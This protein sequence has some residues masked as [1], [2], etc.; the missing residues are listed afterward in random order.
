MAR[1]GDDWIG[2]QA[3]AN[4]R[5]EGINCDYITRD[6]HTPSGVALIMVDRAAENLIGAA[7]SANSTLTP[8]HVAQAEN[9]I[10]ESDVLIVQ[11]EIPLETAAAAIQLARQHT[12]R[13]ILDPALARPLPD[14]ML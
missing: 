13:A 12:V 11:L 5:A 9:A 4:Y 2:D 7:P 10:C 14:E 3:L 8:E 6:R 1:L